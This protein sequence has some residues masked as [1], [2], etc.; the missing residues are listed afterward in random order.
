[1][2]ECGQIQYVAECSP[3]SAVQ[4]P[5]F[6]SIEVSVIFIAYG[7]EK[8]VA[9]IVNGILQIFFSKRNYREGRRDV[10]VGREAGTHG[11]ARACSRRLRLT[12]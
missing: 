8:D 11:C 6:A 12:F 2:A 7:W 9:E 3:F 4:E 5:I 10:Y 1:M